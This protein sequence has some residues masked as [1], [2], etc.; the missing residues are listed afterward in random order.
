MFVEQRDFPG[1]P[2]AFYTAE[3]STPPK[4]LA[5]VSF[6]LLVWVN[7][8]LIVGLLLVSICYRVV[9]SMI[10]PRSIDVSPFTP[11]QNGRSWFKELCI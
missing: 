5:N 4:I 1:G 7:V 10:T 6:A 11:S 2:G 3:Y 8:G 9:D